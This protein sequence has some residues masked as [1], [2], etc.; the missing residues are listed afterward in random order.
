MNNVEKQKLNITKN[1]IKR[2]KKIILN[3]D[4]KKY[5]R[6]YITGGG[7]NGFKYLFC[8]DNAL[9]KN[10]IYIKKKIVLVVD[11]ISFQYLIGSTLDY[12][13]TL[14]SSKFIVINPNAKNTCSC[15]ISF[16][17]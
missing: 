10:D 8:T 16:N 9:K 4:K 14:Q 3:D 11:Y 5:F 12:K 2:I 7:C 13:K 1:A 15:G 6:I 17:I